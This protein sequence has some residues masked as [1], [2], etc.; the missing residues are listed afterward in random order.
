MKDIAAARPIFINR[1]ASL[2][3]G[4]QL[5]IFLLAVLVM[6]PY[7]PA[8]APVPDIDS[9][10]FVYMGSEILQG[11]VPYRDIWDH[12]PPLVYYINA[13][14]LA[15]GGPGR[16]GIWLIEA[17]SLG[18][19]AVMLFSFLRRYFGRA[20]AAVGVLGLLAN[21]GFV[22]ERGNL[23]EEYHMLLQ[24]AVLLLLS[25][26]LARPRAPALA[27]LMGVC[28]GLSVALQFN[29]IGAG[30]S[31]AV[32]LLLSALTERRWV[33]LLDLACL[34]GGAA[35]VWGILAVFFA[36]N[37][38]LSWFWD[39]AFVY[40]LY[41][42]RIGLLER[43]AGLRENFLLVYGISAF[44]TLG[45]LSWLAAAPFLLFYEERF[46]RVLT[47]RWLGFLMLV[48]GVFALSNGVWDD[49]AGR[50]FTLS[51]LSVYRVV[52][53]VTGLAEIV[54]AILILGG[55]VRRLVQN[56]AHS[57]P[58]APV[59]RV[60]FPVGFALLNLP[61]EF[62]L[63]SLFGSGY[64]KSFLPLLL[65]LSILIAY[66]AWSLLA[67]RAT[68]RD[69]G[70]VYLW[71]AALALTAITSGFF[72]TLHP[73]GVAN[74]REIVETAARVRETTQPGQ[75]VLQWGANTSLYFLSERPSASR[76][77]YLQP[78][79]TSGYATPER[80]QA[81]LDELRANPP[82]VLIDTRQEEMLLLLPAGQNC[83]ALDTDD[84][85]ETLLRA[86][87]DSRYPMQ[88]EQPLPDIPQ[89]MRAVYGWLCERYELEGSLSTDPDAWRIYRLRPTEN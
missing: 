63:A 44:F 62:V 27:L 33:R 28:T 73:A 21:L 70:A 54:L 59:A 64:L 56:L 65:S 58:A 13:L 5:L 19:A 89:G 7:N 47:N 85:Y 77:L 51:S 31:A 42:N 36:A 43:V 22:L 15:L 76:Y 67:A 46:Q 48:A 84:G 39:A 50:L 83:A 12:T 72:Y 4:A 68:A 82:E 35:L 53:I 30:L 75:A 87:R 78:L 66:L 88:K 8:A 40:H 25:A 26:A 14:G 45:L 80:V 41:A 79:F 34:I 71:L 69:R 74:A 1:L 86:E 18:A 20:P 37:N 57:E 49:R 29:L 10:V 11:N 60:I 32:I 3:F 2:R 6:L 17:V 55:W 38:A 16:W 9:G 23:P 81:F 52:F 61:F 24:A